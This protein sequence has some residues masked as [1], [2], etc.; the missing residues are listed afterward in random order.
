MKNLFIILLS[1]GILFQ[2]LNKGLIFVNFQVNKE[3]IAKNLCV[4]K[5]IQNNTCKGKCHLKKQ[6]QEAEKKDQSPSQSSKQIEEFQIF[7]QQTLPFQ[8]NHE[9]L[10]NRE[11]TLFT[12]GVTSS[13]SFS[14]FQP[15]RA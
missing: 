10:I 5:A 3:Y 7:C 14:I 12:E 4:K 8:F 9:L 2:S 1:L 13:Y 11:Y 6:L 15:P